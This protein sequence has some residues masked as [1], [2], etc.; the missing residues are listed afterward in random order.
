M[1]LPAKNRGEHFDQGGRKKQGH[2]EIYIL[3]KVIIY[4]NVQK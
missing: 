1:F 4:K 2:E 3:M